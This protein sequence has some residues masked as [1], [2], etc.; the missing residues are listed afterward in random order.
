V[1]SVVDRGAGGRLTAQ[2]AARARTLQADRLLASRWSTPAILTVLTAVSLYLRTRQLNAG[3]WI[4]EGLSVGIAHHH[5]TSI[6]GLLHQD[7]SPPAY[8]LLL[9]LWIRLF[10]DSASATH[11]LSLVFSLGCIPLSFALG[12]SLFGRMTGL[13]CATLAAF[14]PYLTYYAQETRMYSLEAFLSLI[15]ALAYVNGILRGRGPW[16]VVFVLSLDAML[17]VHN[18]A[19]FLCVGL[20]AATVLFA[21]ERLRRFGVAAAGVALLYAPW[22]PTLLEQVRHTGAPWTSAPS[23]RDFVFAPGAV[24]NG[25]A[26]FLAF[27][28]VGG[29]ALVP[30]LRRRGDD[31]R[32]T[33]LT[34]ALA[35]EVTVLLAWILSQ[36]SPAWATRYFAVVLG[37]LLV[38]AA[39]GVVR[40]R[41]LGLAAFV[42]VLFLWT[43][44]SVTDNKENAREV[45]A[46]LA[47]SIRP[48]ELVIST[49]PEQV[50]VLRYYLGARPR[51][52]STLGA[53]T[54][55]QIFDWRDAVDRLRAA[56]PRPTLDALLQTVAP[57]SEFVV[58]TPV[59]RDYRAWRAKWTHLVW[60]RSIQWTTLLANDP[61][62]RLVRHISS[63][64]IALHVNYFKP[65][66]A[67]VYRR[68]R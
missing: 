18:W 48:G 30:V 63:N 6:P 4:D 62:V 38:V 8:Y 41:R 56:R 24:F 9:G 27:A 50:P 64:E 5:L 13:C 3:F 68:L 40:A 51:F 55:S 60:Q 36:A 49:H 54:D 33:I 21:R 20:A 44:Y 58:I 22:V 37:P 28:L 35:A 45:T 15:V 42:V 11:T 25:D 1:A 46:A 47:P 32:A 57:G 7:G 66:Q 12:R 26:P 19:L 31:E 34:L 65:L 53:V 67:F 23:F 29:A 52:A 16:V 14:D 61:R 17:Y 10:G 43:G 59:F 2:L 39:R